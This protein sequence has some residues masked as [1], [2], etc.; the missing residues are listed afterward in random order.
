LSP[1][2]P[3]LA[4]TV[5]AGAAAAGAPTAVAAAAAAGEALSRAG[6][7][8]LWKR[9]HLDIVRAL[10]IAAA[11]AA[12]PRGAA[13][14]AMSGLGYTPTAT[15]AARLLRD[16]GFW[17]AEAEPPPPPPPPGASANGR[18]SSLSASKSAS[19]APPPARARSDG[20]TAGWTFPPDVL[21]E[22]RRLRA[23][24][25]RRRVGFATG[26]TAVGRGR[27][28]CLAGRGGVWAVDDPA[29]RFLDDAITIR[30][31]RAKSVGDR[32]VWR[33]TVHIADV[34]AVV[35]VGTAMDT[36]ARERGESL[37]LPARPL[38]MLPAAAMEG[39]GFSKDLP[40]ETVAVQMDVDV[41][42]RALVD[43]DVFAAVVG[44][45]RR[46][47]YDGF[48]AALGGGRAAPRTSAR[49]DGDGGGVEASA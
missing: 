8:A 35:S 16:I 2:P 38:H 11:S 23:A 19:T 1:S 33:V 14:A 41:G 15:E 29:A 9:E 45:V 22:A 44:P 24:A 10:E 32:D 37:Y 49:R 46:V 26:A 5:A 4:S 21:D 25:R 28:N 7:K 13:A 18:P 39:A 27:R 40:T 17:S 30:R 3:S 20:V 48:N 47:T 6:V 36:L 43:W 31:V 34:D 42:A 12:V